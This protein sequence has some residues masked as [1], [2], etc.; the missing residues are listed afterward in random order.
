MVFAEDQELQSGHEK[1]G[2]E[3]SGQNK[4]GLAKK[5]CQRAVD[6]LSRREHSY[7]EL[8]KKLEGRLKGEDGTSEIIIEVLDNLASKG[9]QIWKESCLTMV[10]N[11]NK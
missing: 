1:Y 8:Q 9:L 5:V 7:Q 6:L 4:N 2:Q 10:V 3:G 11:L